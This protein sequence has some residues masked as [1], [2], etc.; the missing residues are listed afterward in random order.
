MISMSRIKKELRSGLNGHVKIHKTNQETKEPKKWNLVKTALGGVTEV[1]K[2][3][4]C[5]AKAGLM[6]FACQ[7]AS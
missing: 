5:S 1:I 7:I 4:M 3:K 6:G 2:N